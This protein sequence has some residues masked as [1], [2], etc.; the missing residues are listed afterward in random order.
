MPCTGEVSK[1]PSMYT[2]S[3]ISPMTWNEDVKFGPPTPKKMRTISPTL[4]WSGWRRDKAP[5]EPKDLEIGSRASQHEW[6][7]ASR[8]K[9]PND[10][11]KAYPQQRNIECQ[12]QPSDPGRR[13]QQLLANTRDGRT[14]KIE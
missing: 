12:D 13:C 3:K 9:L 5:S 6:L 8:V 7:L 4:A 14:H 10:E 1:P 2:L 11:A